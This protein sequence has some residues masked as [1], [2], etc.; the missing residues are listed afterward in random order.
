MKD[1][2]TAT[3]V[4]HSSMSDYLKCPRLYYLRNVYRDPK[5]RH[6]VS[7][8]TPPLALGQIVHD[9]IDGLSK[10]PAGDRF[11]KSLVE[12]FEKSWESVSGKRGGFKTKDEEEV[13]KAKGIA[14][15]ERVEK[16]KGPLVN[17][18]IKLRQELPH[19]WLSEDENIILCG[20][21]DWLEYVAETDSVNILD[22]KTGKHD[23]D[24]DS[25]QLPIYYLIVSHCQ[26]RAIGKLYYW[27]LDRDDEPLE[28]EGIDVLDAEKRV[29]ELAKKVALAR[30]LEHFVC[31]KKEGCRYCLPYEAILAGQAE[32]V[33]QNTF[34]QDLYIELA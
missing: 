24:P 14:M 28:T 5:T 6:K 30:K 2:F 18:A 33:G 20:K 7:L 4:S 32:L 29:M 22:F 16:N 17:K 12:S 13:F 15:I 26:T 19:Y 10:L 3:W 11:S 9:T 34:G 8:I 1:K 31:K 21:I 23:E 25:L 27:Y